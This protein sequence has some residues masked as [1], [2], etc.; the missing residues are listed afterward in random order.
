MTHLL[1]F[2][3]HFYSPTILLIPL[4]QY[5][6]RKYFALY[7]CFCIR[8]SFILLLIK[9]SEVD[10]NVKPQTLVGTFD[11]ANSNSFPVPLIALLTYPVSI[12][13]ADRSF[14]GWIDCKLLTKDHDRREIELSCN[15]AHARTQGRYWYWWRH[16]KIL[17]VWRVH[18]SAFAC[19]CETLNWK[20]LWESMPPDS[21]RLGA[22]SAL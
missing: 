6:L 10:P 3:A 18:V 15:S 1:Y 17:L 7:W 16:K 22:H 13:T 8:I 4:R 12:C 9:W 2:T 19:I 14:S 21:P 5:C 11:Q 20:I